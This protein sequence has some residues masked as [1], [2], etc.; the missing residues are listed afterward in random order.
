MPLPIFASGILV[1]TMAPWLGIRPD[2]TPD[3]IRIAQGDDII[4][5]WRIGPNVANFH[6]VVR[7]LALNDSIL[8]EAADYSLQLLDLGSE[9]L[10]LGLLVVDSLVLSHNGDFPARD[11]LVCLCSCGEEVLRRDDDNFV[12]IPAFHESY[13]FGCRVWFSWDV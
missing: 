6:L 3:R 11:G 10:D 8:F 7:R 2:L 12:L 4:V 13:E 9:V 1:E 5:S